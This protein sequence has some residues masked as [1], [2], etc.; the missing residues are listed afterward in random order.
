MSV[1]TVACFMVPFYARRSRRHRSICPLSALSLPVGLRF[2]L[3]IGR[4]FALVRHDESSFGIDL[5]FDTAPTRTALT[6][7]SSIVGER[8]N[9]SLMNK[10]APE[11]T[12]VS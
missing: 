11:M 2:L 3:L 4:C 12:P 10:M 1:V 5:H 8:E 7:N 6:T 9:S